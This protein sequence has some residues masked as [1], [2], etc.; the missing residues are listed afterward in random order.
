MTRI[1]GRTSFARPR[2]EVFD[3]L[4][5]PRHEPEYNPLVLSAR[6]EIPGMIGPGPRFSQRVKSFG[7]AGEVSI[8]LVDCE[9][10]DA[11]AQP[12]LTPLSPV[13]PAPGPW[14]VGG[15]VLFFAV[16]LLGTD[17]FGLQ[18]DLADSAPV[19]TGNPAGAFLTH[20]T[21]HVSAVVHQNEGGPTQMLP[22]R[23]QHHAGAR[24]PVVGVRHRRHAGRPAG[25]LVVRLA[26]LRE[27]LRPWTVWP[28]VAPQS[29]T[30]SDDHLRLQA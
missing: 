22:D 3:L 23:L 16:P 8:A 28:G 6:K 2:D 17:T 11:P 15:A 21:A 26:P 20:G 9:R 25:P 13:R 19:L 7:R 12:G 24:V 5:D 10:P 30:P 18:P 14:L 27:A 29:G 4:A 1:E